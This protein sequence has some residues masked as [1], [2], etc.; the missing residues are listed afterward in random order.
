MHK[1]ATL[2]PLTLTS[3]VAMRLSQGRHCNISALP[4]VCAKPNDIANTAAKHSP[5]LLI[6]ATSARNA[7]QKPPKFIMRK[8]WI[9]QRVWIV[10]SSWVLELKQLQPLGGRNIVASPDT[11]CT[12]TAQHSTA[13]HSTAQPFFHDTE[14]PSMLTESHKLCNAVH[15]HM[16]P[17][18]QAIIPP[19]Q[20]DSM[21]HNSAKVASLST[22]V[23]A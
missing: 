6:Y 2:R 16:A 22:E 12:C 14:R 17:S 1:V 18:A 15:T 21:S 11:A 19:L 5:S 7:R 10:H 4:K 13:Q 3:A 9:Q 8:F 23:K 20:H